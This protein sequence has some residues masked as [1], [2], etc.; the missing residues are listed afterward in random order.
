[1]MDRN[2]PAGIGIVGGVG[3][4][5]GIDLVAK[6]IANTSASRDQDHLPITLV[7]WPELIGDRTEFL[8]EQGKANPGDALAKILLS[9]E[10]LGCVVSGI[11]CNTAHS[12]LIFNRVL[13]ILEEQ[14]SSLRLVHMLKEVAEFLRLNYVG[15]QSIGVLSTTGTYKTKI[16]PGILEPLGFKVVVPDLADQEEL[17]HRAIYDPEWGIKAQSNPVTEQARGSLEA[18]MDDLKEKGAQAIILGCT[19]IPLAFPVLKFADL[20]LIDPTTILARALIRE[21]DPTKLRPMVI[22]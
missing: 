10:S 16:Y 6:V 1:M 7:S 18:A 9:L 22:S 4:S 15:L 12:P 13:T 21:L 11:P 14:G 2:L 19:E 20:P 8:M 3:P 17:V 5:A